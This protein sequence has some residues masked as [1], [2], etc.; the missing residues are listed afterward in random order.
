MPLPNVH[1]VSAAVAGI[2]IAG[3]WLVFVVFV[4][5]TYPAYPSAPGASKGAATTQACS[6]ERPDGRLMY[7]GAASCGPT[8]VVVLDW[9]GA[10]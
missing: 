5:Q 4:L 10:L 6:H 9:H 2:V 8:G 3:Y 7:Q 1:S